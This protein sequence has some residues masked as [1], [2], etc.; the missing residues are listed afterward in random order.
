MN[1]ED[2]LNIILSHNCPNGEHFL[3]EDDRKAGVQGW[4]FE[5]HCH[6]IRIKACLA[7]ENSIHLDPAKRFRYEIVDVSVKDGGEGVR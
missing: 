2:A 7:E 5:G 4:E 1:H 3:T 6:I